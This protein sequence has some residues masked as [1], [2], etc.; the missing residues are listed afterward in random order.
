MAFDGSKIRNLLDRVASNGSVHGIAAVVVDRNGQIFHHAAGE[1][2]E[3]SMFRN[4]SLTKASVT[5]GALQLVERGLLAL[6]TTVES[7]L[8]EFGKLQVLDGFDGDKPRLRDPAI[9]ATVRH[10]MTHTAG[11]AYFFFNEKLLHYHG[12]TGEPT[13]MTGLR[14]SLMSPLVNDPGTAWT[15]GV[16]TDWLGLVIE[17]ITGKRLS[18]YL[19]ENVYGPLGM[20]DT[21]F[22]PSDVQRAQLLRVMQ[23]RTDGALAPSEVDLAPAPEWDAGGHGSYGTVQDFG[24][25]V[26]AWLAIT[27][28]VLEPATLDLA[29]ENHLGS[30]TLPDLMQSS[31]PILSNDVPAA[32]VEQGWGLG[33][34]LT[35]ADIP[36]LRSAKSADWAGVF[37]SY[38]WMDR[39][40]GVG[41][42]LMTQLLPFFDT[43]VVDT[44]MEFEMEVY[45]ETNLRASAA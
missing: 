23:R 3:R 12:V 24:R 37:N 26:Q 20:K 10:L 40:K 5:M 39:K 8:P 21:T 18:E 28:G 2:S 45:R 34:H 30:V 15:Y 29:L 16:S 36:G 22:A 14:R 41:G 27:P 17:N 6:D 25:L 32:P 7:I 35:L 19:Q 11:L 13:P 43:A 9:A 31:A 33:F 44:F 1:A 4:A 42:V 38:F